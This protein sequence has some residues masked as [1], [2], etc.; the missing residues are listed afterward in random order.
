MGGIISGFLKGAGQAT[1]EAGKMMLADQLAKERDEAN[2]LRD[3]SLRKD[4]SRDR[5]SHLSAENKLRREYDTESAGTENDQRVLAAKTK[6]GTDVEQ[7]RLDREARS[8]DNKY[9]VD[10]RPDRDRQTVDVDG[11]NGLVVEA[12]VNEDGSVTLPTVTGE[13]RTI[14][15]STDDL[16]GA[17]QDFKDL[18]ID[19]G[20]YTSEKD[21]KDVTGGL[22]KKEYIEKKAIERFLKRERETAATGTTVAP[23][24]DKDKDEDANAGAG[25]VVASQTN[26]AEPA[27]DAAEPP[28]VKNFGKNDR[29]FEEYSALM[30]ERFGE[31]GITDDD[32]K[33][34]WDKRPWVTSGSK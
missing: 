16:A 9:S 11:G 24:V 15:P 4:L 30:K 32:I 7:S 20:M 8:A 2:W 31:E 22:S 6:S 14:N 21:I 27:T 5:L 12:F 28:K 10:G 19:G 18:E 25:G 33:K 34:E 1:G 29:T 13:G 26:D 23:V 3:S 17:A